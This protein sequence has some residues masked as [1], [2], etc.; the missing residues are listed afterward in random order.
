MVFEWY[1]NGTSMV[2]WWSVYITIQNTIQSSTI[3]I[4]MATIRHSIIQITNQVPLNSTDKFIPK[5]HPTYQR[6]T[7]QIP[8]IITPRISLNAIEQRENDYQKKVSLKYH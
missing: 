4:S 7:I 5:H 8:F 1:L 2:L 6:R 3:Q